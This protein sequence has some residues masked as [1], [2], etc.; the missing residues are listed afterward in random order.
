ME[1]IELKT[2]IDI[3]DTGVRRA[4]QGTAQ[5]L[6]Q[7]KNFT[8]LKQCV[9]ITSIIGYD[10]S[11]SCESVDVKNLGFGSNF[12]GKHRVW[13][14]RF[15]PDRANSF[16]NDFGALGALTATLEDIPVI[17]NLT[18]TINIDRPVFDL[19]DSLLKNTTIRITTGNE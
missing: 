4:T 19:S 17:K 16:A 3:T 18:E 10:A 15:Y 12:K 8:T 14:W 6:D 5:Q 13:T 11:P 2:L 9:E 1:I 7:Y